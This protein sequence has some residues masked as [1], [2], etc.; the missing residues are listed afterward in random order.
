[1]AGTIASWCRAVAAAVVLTAA[2]AVSAAA[3]PL[4][5]VV[6][7]GVVRIAVYRDFPPFSY[8]EDGVLKG[9]DVDLGKAIGEKLGLRVDFMELTA[10]ET[11]DDDLRNA[12]W[13]GPILGGGVADIM[14]HVPVNR[15][16]A[17]RN[18]LVVIFGAYQ[19]E[20][21]AVARDPARVSETAGFPVFQTE[22]VGVELDTVPD[23]YLSGAFGG[24]LAANVVHY[25]NVGQAV[26]GLRAGAVAAVFAP[27]SELEGA[28]GPDRAKFPIGSMPAPNL[29]PAEWP[30]GLAVKHDARDL[31]YRVGDIVT[32]LLESGKVTE[33]YGNHGL[34]HNRPAQ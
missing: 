22:K 14:M 3:V 11:M 17:Q 15:T 27:L 13:K 6:A 20:T 26:A 23:F 18:D 30:I 8:R 28:L 1:M 4:D 2:T 10:D 34:T 33:I 16:F 5:D 21:Y 32:E 7:R 12:V 24:R 25:T 31:G 29:T 19:R 9:A